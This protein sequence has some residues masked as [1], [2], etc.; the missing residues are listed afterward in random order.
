VS[1]YIE[2]ATP[3]EVKLATSN[4]V[5]RASSKQILTVR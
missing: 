5:R 1:I 2:S 3:H 4:L